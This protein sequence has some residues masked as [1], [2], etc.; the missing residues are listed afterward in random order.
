MKTSF[1]STGSRTKRPRPKSPRCREIPIRCWPQY[2][3]VAEILQAYRNEDFRTA[4]QLYIDMDASLIT[5]DNMLNIFAGIQ[6]DMTAN[7]PAELE[8]MAAEAE[9]AGGS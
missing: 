5:D 3:T 7:A 2:A 6:A 8:A 1:P 9:A 4:V